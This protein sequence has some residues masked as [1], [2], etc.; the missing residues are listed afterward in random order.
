MIKAAWDKKYPNDSF[1][2]VVL[3]SLEHDSDA[4]LGATMS[5]KNVSALTAVTYLAESLHMTV[6]HG[7]DIVVLRP[8]M[9][10]DENAWTTVMLSLSDASIKAL[11]L[12]TTAEGDKAVDGALRKTLG[13]LGLSF[14]SDFCSVWWHGGSKQLLVRN[15]PEEVS[16][17]KGLLML[18]D[19]GVSVSRVDN[20]EHGEQEGVDGKP[21]QSSQSPR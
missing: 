10:L 15:T 5:L 14:E 16:K 7:L 1:P 8:V 21:P 3:E 20:T 4:A 2:V 19:A 13:S 17:L 12:S 6:R 9:I 11:R 18:F